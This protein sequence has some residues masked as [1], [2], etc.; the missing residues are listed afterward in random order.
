VQS[1]RDQ[2]E[3]R[4]ARGGQTIFCLRGKKLLKVADEKPFIPT[5][6]CHQDVAR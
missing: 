3:I 2:G 6:M 4:K 5:R 1:G